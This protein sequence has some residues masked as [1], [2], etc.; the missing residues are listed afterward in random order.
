MTRGSAP[1]AG[2]YPDPSGRHQFR[3][4]SGYAWTEHVSDAGTASVDPLP[5]A[6]AGAATGLAQRGQSGQ[7]ALPGRTD[8]RQG[9]PDEREIKDQQRRPTAPAR[10]SSPRRHDRRRRS[11]RRLTAPARR[12]SPR[13]R[14]KPR[15]RRR[16][17]GM[18]GMRT[19]PPGRRSSASRPRLPARQ[20]PTRRWRAW[21]RS[22]RRRKPRTRLPHRNGCS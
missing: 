16:R 9:R 22:A 5:A 7:G 17:P 10:R 14:S 11:R 1:A 12:N 21:R 2:W 20:R 15:R 18:P 6:P 3:F 19:R 4:W 13:L 8:R